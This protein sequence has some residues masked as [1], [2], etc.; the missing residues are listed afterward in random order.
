MCSDDDDALA[1][2]VLV[3]KGRGVRDQKAQGS[4]PGGKVVHVA[5]MR[6]EKTKPEDEEAAK[7]DAK[8]KPKEK[9]Q[10]E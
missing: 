4:G 8:E 5:P 9:P 2:Q 3:A 6:K 1:D 7:H 10:P